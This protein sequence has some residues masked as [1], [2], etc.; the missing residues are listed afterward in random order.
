MVE[1]IST[2]SSRVENWIVRFE[3]HIFSENDAQISRFPENLC[4]VDQNVPFP[5]NFPEIGLC[6]TTQKLLYIYIYIYLL[7]MILLFGWVIQKSFFSR[8]EI[9]KSATGWISSSFSKF[10]FLISR[11][12]ILDYRI[13]PENTPATCSKCNFCGFEVGRF[14]TIMTSWSV[15]K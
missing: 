6:V 9:L 3:L 15:V 1:M 11:F 7:S 8:P 2:K 10:Q 12:Y 5:E 14:V 4:I 13:V